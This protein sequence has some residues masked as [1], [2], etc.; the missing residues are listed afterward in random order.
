MTPKDTDLL[1]LFRGPSGGTPR[2]A[3]RAEKA[4]S[5]GARSAT[6]SLDRRRAVLAAAAAVLVVMLAFVAGVG[7]GRAKSRGTDTPVAARLA[8]GLAGATWSLI[9]AP[10][11]PVGLSGESLPQK[12]RDELV[13]KWPAFSERVFEAIPASPVDASARDSGHRVLV[14]T[15]FSDWNSAQNVQYQ[16]AVFSVVGAGCPFQ[17]S[18][19]ERE[20]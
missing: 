5:S 10:I 8:R 9:S 4:R 7:I 18:V 17:G 2:R 1:D 20:R 12:V 15:G 11:P 16:L 14:I 3:A 6:I 13:R 19:P